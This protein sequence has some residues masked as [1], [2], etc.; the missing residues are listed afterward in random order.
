MPQFRSAPSRHDGTAQRFLAVAAELI[1]AYLCA[2]ADRVEDSARLRHIRFPTALEWLRT[3]DIIRLSAST[4]GEAAC[5]REFFRR[6]PTRDEFLPDAVVYAL[7]REYEAPDPRP[8]VASIPT[9]SQAIAPTSVMVVG[10]AEGLLTALVRHPRSYLMLHIGPLLPRHPQ[11]GSALVPTTRA[12]ARV[13]EGLYEQLVTGLDLVM[14]PEWSF[15]RASM[16]LHAMLDGFVL[17]YRLLAGG[18]PTSRWEGAGVFADAII[19]FILG[20]VDW[21]LT[22]Q[23]GQ[24]ALDSLVQP[25]LHPVRR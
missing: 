1:D 5:R 21:D 16:V 12:V 25:T 24:A 17:R 19:A 23:S 15:E 4:S 13:W 22:G 7:L 20:G 6:W 18:R 11:L 3:E 9:I 8:Y 10:I 2:G 14:R